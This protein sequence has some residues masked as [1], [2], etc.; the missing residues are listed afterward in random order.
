LSSAIKINPIGL[1][2]CSCKEKERQEEI[3]SLLFLDVYDQDLFQ[4][5]KSTLKVFKD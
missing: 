1:K 4:L 3:P 5:A 2:Y